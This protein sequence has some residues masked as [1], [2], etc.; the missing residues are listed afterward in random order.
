M[1]LIKLEDFIEKYWNNPEYENNTF[2]FG[3]NVV[4][5]RS[6]LNESNTKIRFTKSPYFPQIWGEIRENRYGLCVG[7]QFRFNE[8]R[9]LDMGE[10]IKELKIDLP[11][12]EIL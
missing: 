12:E 4:A 7:V 3:E 1:V 6:M 2:A 5:M 10:S 9:I 8:V 11:E